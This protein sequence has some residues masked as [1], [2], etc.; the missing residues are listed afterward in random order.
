LLKNAV[1]AGDY[2]MPTVKLYPFVKYLDMLSTDDNGLVIKDGTKLVFPEATRIQWIDY[3]QNLHS[4]PQKVIKRAR[5][6][7]WWPFINSDLKQQRITCKSCVK[8]SPSNPSDQIKLHKPAVYPFQCIHAD[9]GNY[10][11]KQWIIIMDQFSGWPLIR[12]LGKEAL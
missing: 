4:S 12:N 1:V 10:S 7:I 11:G 6:S 8:R 9:L 3:L 2:R 5:K